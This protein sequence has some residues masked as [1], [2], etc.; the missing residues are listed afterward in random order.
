MFSLCTEVLCTNAKCSHWTGFCQS[1]GAMDLN[2]D[3]FVANRLLYGPTTWF[4]WVNICS[5][6]P[7]QTEQGLREPGHVLVSWRLVQRHPKQ[8]SSQAVGISTAGIRF[9]NMALNAAQSWLIHF[10][11]A[12]V[13]RLINLPQDGLWLWSFRHTWGQSNK[14]TRTVMGFWRVTLDPFNFLICTELTSFENEMLRMENC[15]FQNN[16]EAN[17][18]NFCME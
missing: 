5:P 2:P 12:V 18:Y 3:Y 7:F 8:Q 17:Y 13:L 16:M 14:K 4:L 6:K 10:F 15:Y 1:V 11:V 9:S